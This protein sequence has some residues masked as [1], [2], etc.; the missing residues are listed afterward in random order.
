MGFFSNGSKKTKNK[1]PL[2][3]REFAGIQKKAELAWKKYSSDKFFD[4]PC[5]KLQARQSFIAGYK[6]CKMEEN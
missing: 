5:E 4:D 6:A 1:K 3:I 2:E